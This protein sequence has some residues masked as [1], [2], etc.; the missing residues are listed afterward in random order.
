MPISHT[1]EADGALTGL[2]DLLARGEE[3]IITRGGAAVARLAPV[4]PAPDRTA[5]REAAVRIAAMRQ[6]VTLDGLSTRAL[7]EEGRR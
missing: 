7:I 2:L 6:G 5:A 4:P 3:V 1:L